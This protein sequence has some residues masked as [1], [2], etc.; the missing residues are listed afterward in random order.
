MGHP[1]TLL[2]QDWRLTQLK[3]LFNYGLCEVPNV[4]ID[5][6]RK[7]MLYLPT[8]AIYMLKFKYLL[9]F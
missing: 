3:F 7:F 6:A 2:K 9:F 1:E 4:G 5:L 8:I